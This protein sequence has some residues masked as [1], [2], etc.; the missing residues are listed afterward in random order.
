MLA[1]RLL[2]LGAA[3]VGAVVLVSATHEGAALAD[4]FFDTDA[5]PPIE[6]GTPPSIT[7]TAAAPGSDLDAGVVLML[8]QPATPPA[9]ADAGA[10]G[11]VDAADAAAPTADVLPTAKPLGPDDAGTEYTGLSVGLRGGFALPGGRAKTSALSDVVKYVVP[12][13]VDVGYYLRPNLYVGAYFLYGFAGTSTS[14]QDACPSGTDTT[15]SAQSYKWGV[16]L[17]YAFWHTR[18]WSPWVRGGIGFDVINLTANDS[19]GKRAQSSSLFGMEWAVLS[20]G[21]DWKPGYFYGI[22]PYAE[23]ALGDYGK[24]DGVADPHFFATFGL[25]ARTGLFVP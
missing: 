1:H 24:K 9:D 11:A 8:P 19:A 15:C 25:R 10:V 18:T 6:A 5:A 14:S 23:L 4:V 22:G 21:L 2:L 13:G 12:L 16:V 20:G 17:E 7:P 3:C